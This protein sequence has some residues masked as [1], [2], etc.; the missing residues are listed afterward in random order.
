MKEL[1]SHDMLIIQ[2]MGTTSMN[3]AQIGLD[4][5]NNHTLEQG[6]VAPNLHRYK[7]VMNIRCHCHLHL[8]QEVL[9]TL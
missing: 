4:H 5:D 6:V 3:Q 8:R 9:S 7:D 1:F 2:M